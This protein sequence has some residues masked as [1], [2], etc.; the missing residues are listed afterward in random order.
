F[1]AYGRLFAV[2]NDP[3]ARG[4]CRLLHVVQ[5]GDYGFR[6]RYGRKGTHPFQCWAGELPGTLGFVAGTGGA[7]AGV[8]AYES[9]GLPDE[10]RGD[11][12]STS[13]GDH[14]I[15]RFHLLPNGASFQAQA[16]TVVRG[17]DDFR[18]VAIAV[19]PDGAVYF[20]D[21]VDKSYPVHGKGRIWR[22]RAKQTPA[23]DS[24]RPSQVPGLELGKLIELLGHPRKEI[25]SAATEAL[26]TKGAA[27]K[28]ALA[29][30]LR[31]KNDRRT[32]LH[33]LWAAARMGNDGTDLVAAAVRDDAA[34]V[35]AEAVRLLPR[36]D[37]PSGT[38][39]LDRALKDTS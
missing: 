3:D 24:L 18:P 17:D 33:A 11:L 25:R 23:V 6:F 35:R 10:Y 15:E 37:G 31:G 29:S 9:T 21:W 22:L 26:A 32:K 30:V 20:S 38:L 12:L 14:L 16:Q 1:D 5:G 27:S 34:E 13:W 39:R 8:A 19:G 7:P 28:F 2:D 4:P 36:D